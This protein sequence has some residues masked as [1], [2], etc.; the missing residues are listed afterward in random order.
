MQWVKQNMPDGDHSVLQTGIMCIGH[1]SRHFHF[2]GHDLWVI[3]YVYTRQ[4]LG[5]VFLRR[6]FDI[7]SLHTTGKSFID[8]S[9]FATFAPLKV[10]G[11]ESGPFRGVGPASHHP[12]GLTKLAGLAPTHVEDSAHAPLADLVTC[13]ARHSPETILIILNTHKQINYHCFL[14]CGIGLRSK[15]Y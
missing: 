9:S 11:N 3:R 7:S 2:G 12:C 14:P 5:E 15:K 6:I 8:K 13:W 1:E 10:V 4:D